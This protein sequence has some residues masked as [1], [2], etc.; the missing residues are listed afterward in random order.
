MPDPVLQHPAY[1]T[2]DRDDFSF[3]TPGAAAAEEPADARS[4]LA[5]A[6]ALLA[7]LSQDFSLSL[8]IATTLER[9]LAL[10]AAQLDAEAGS[11][12]LVE[13]EG[14][15]IACHA[16]VGP[17]PITGLRLPAGEGIVGRSVR[18]NLAQC[19]LDVAKDPQFSQL[20]DAQSGLR[21]ALDPVRSAVAR[22]A[23]DRRD[24]ADQQ[25]NRRWALQRER[26]AQAPGAG[27]G[28][29]ARDRA[30][31]HG[32]IAGRARAR[33]PRARARRRN[34]AR[35]AAVA[36]TGTLSRVRRS[37]RVAHGRLR[38]LRHRPARG[39][40]RILRRRRR[41]SGRPHE[42]VDG[43]D[44]EL[45]SLPGEDDREPERAA[46]GA[47]AGALRTRAARQLRP[48][49]RGQLRSGER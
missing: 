39:P 8:D 47:R 46:R 14:L 11:L 2:P 17:H 7:K 23:R 20:L 45:V 35:A 12:W 27:V 5:D 19:V 26:C 42:S 34:P 31:A 16:C 49:G 4:D 29:G 38:F 40:D 25:P 10:I 30:R 6:F 3:A 18:D 44:G 48:A 22:R 21:D 43:E 15:E 28:G 32:G 41:G 9:A 33:A 13:S 37:P 24:R 36:A 1:A